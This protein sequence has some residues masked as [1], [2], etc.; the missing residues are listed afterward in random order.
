[1]KKSIKII[2]LV[3]MTFVLMA[4]SK[5]PVEEVSARIIYPDGLP[6]IGISKFINDNKKIDNYTIESEL[7]KTPDALVAELLKSEADIAVVPSNLALQV[8][9]KGLE[10]K[11]AGTI[12]L[13]SLYLITT[14]DITDINELQSK[15]IY[16]TGKGLTPDLIGKEILNSK[17]LTED[18]VNYSYVSAASELAP[19]II[20]GKAKYAIV[21]EPVLSTI[22]SKKSNVKILLDFNKEWME[23]KD[24]KIGFPQ[25]TLLIKEKFYNDNKKLCKKIVGNIKASIDWVNNNPDEAG[26]ISESIGISVNKDIL[27]SALDRANLKFY[28]IQD[29]KNEYIKFFEVIDNKELNEEGKTTYEEVFIKE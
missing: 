1:M 5:K 22:M 13:G 3:S 18:K 19:M 26:V 14:E 17:G 16:N 11:V 10:Y 29:T 27:S 24:T 23:S 6:A 9:N 20:S 21:S 28:N 12:G 25:S 7:Q 4:C 8:H 15:E 2:I